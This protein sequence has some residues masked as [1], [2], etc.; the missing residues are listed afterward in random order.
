MATGYED[1]LIEAVP[2]SFA[3]IM[4]EFGFSLTRV[5]EWLVEL[6]S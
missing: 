4:A 3:S 5:K 2:Q 6:E 1:A